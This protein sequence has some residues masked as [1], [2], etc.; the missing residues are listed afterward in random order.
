MEQTYVIERCNGVIVAKLKCG[1]KIVA[2][3]N[4]KGE[5][6]KIFDWTNLPPQEFVK[7]KI[8]AGLL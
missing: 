2:E 8:I 1:D 3:Y 7:Q 4:G 6:T 5:P